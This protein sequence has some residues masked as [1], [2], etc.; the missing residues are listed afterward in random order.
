MLTYAKAK[1]G[2]MYDVGVDPPFVEELRAKLY[3]R[4]KTAEV[5][6]A[7]EREEPVEINFS[8]HDEKEVEKVVE[9]KVKKKVE[10]VVPKKKA[11][12]RKKAAPKKTVL[13]S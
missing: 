1:C 3:G 9:K 13:P 10:K 6:K 11:A 12:P 2:L 8:F 7:V 5:A 4:D